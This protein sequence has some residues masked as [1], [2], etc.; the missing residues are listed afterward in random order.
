MRWTV[1]ML[2]LCATGAH[3]ACDSGDALALAKSIFVDHR[4]FAA[5]DPDTLDFLS[6]A[7]RE[8]LHRQCGPTTPCQH[9]Q[10]VWTST[11]ERRVRNPISIQSLTPAGRSPALV[12]LRFDFE[13]HAFPRWQAARLRFVCDE[14]SG[15]WQFDDLERADGKHLGELPLP[16]A[17]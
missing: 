14:A 11:P 13:G 2:G 15:R 1:I 12:D 5:Q 17:G 16:P 4:D 9:P 8:Q 10:F 6:P 3:A 7:L